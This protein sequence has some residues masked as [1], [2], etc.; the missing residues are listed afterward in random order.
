ML[1]TLLCFDASSHRNAADESCAMQLEDHR[2]RALW[3]GKKL[4]LKAAALR[5]M[6]EHMAAKSMSE[7]GLIWAVRAHQAAAL[8]LYMNCLGW[9]YHVC[10]FR[11][12]THQMLIHISLQ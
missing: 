5:K 3:L 8:R 2:A 10:V 1:L 11:Q 7:E 9:F 4:S 6:D 12:W